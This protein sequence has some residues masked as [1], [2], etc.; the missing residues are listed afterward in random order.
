MT[1]FGDGPFETATVLGSGPNAMHVRLPLAPFGLVI[2]LVAVPHR[3]ILASLDQFLECGLAGMMHEGFLRAYDPIAGGARA[4]GVIV[5]LEHSNREA[6]IQQPDLIE[7]L[8]AHG[9]TE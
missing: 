3:L 7:Y 1:H 4:V 2:G 8:A 6:L 9:E 5:V